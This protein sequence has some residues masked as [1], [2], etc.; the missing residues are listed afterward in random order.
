MSHEEVFQPNSLSSGHPSK[1]PKSNDRRTRSTTSLE[2][3]SNS[4]LGWRHCLAHSQEFK[5]KIVKTPAE[6]LILSSSG[7]CLDRRAHPRKEA[8]I[9]RSQFR[10]SNQCIQDVINE[11]TQHLVWDERVCD[12][13]SVIKN[14]KT[15]LCH[16]WVES[17]FLDCPKTWNL[18]ING[19]TFLHTFIQ[20]SQTLNRQWNEFSNEP[21]ATKLN[22]PCF[23]E[24][25]ISKV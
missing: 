16:I 24:T 20:K 3:G 17:C 22:F 25:T 4:Y 23:Y 6:R 5:I 14:S 7:Y 11:K 15:R 2:Q 12:M 8:P 19:T 18:L 21:K 9:S 1:L 10:T 13:K